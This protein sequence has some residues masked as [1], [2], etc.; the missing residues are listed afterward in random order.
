MQNAHGVRTLIAQKSTKQQA[1]YLDNIELQLFMIWKAFKSCSIY[2][3]IHNTI[4]RS[5]DTLRNIILLKHNWAAFAKMV[6]NKSKSKHQTDTYLWSNDDVNSQTTWSYTLDMVD[7][8]HLLRYIDYNI[9]I[10]ARNTYC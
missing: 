3:V 10:S 2:N 7:T 1:G 8:K 6:I 5:E 4:E 9:L